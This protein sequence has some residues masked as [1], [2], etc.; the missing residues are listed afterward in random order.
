M[1]PGT[2][3]T[4]PADVYRYLLP[5]ERVLAVVRQHPAVL[6]FP[7]AAA[8]GGLLAATAV[9]Q[10]PHVASSALLIVWIFAALLIA[11]LILAVMNWS[12][13]YIVLTEDRMLVL[14]GLFNRTVIVVRLTDL[15]NLT[16]ERSSTG[17]ITGHGSM[18]IGPSGAPQAVID[19][20]PYPDRLYLHIRM[21]INGTY[22]QETT[23]REED[24]FQE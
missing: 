21:I 17:R 22:R 10:I 15:E 12:I 4:N 14:S 6:T 1:T 19:F 9:S 23:L 16:F 20:V 2:T 3:S 24:P 5:E 13:Y 8:L 18:T 11:R 7:L